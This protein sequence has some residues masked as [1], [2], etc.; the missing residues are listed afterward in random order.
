MPTSAPPPGD[1]A[2]ALALRTT[3]DGV[4]APVRVTPRSSRTRVRGTRNGRLVV[5]LNA[6]PVDGA[7]NQA[8]VR[9][10]ATHLNVPR[11]AVRIVG[12]EHTRQKSV[13][14]T[15]LTAT[16]ILDQLERQT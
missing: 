14:V 5:Q 15:G 4:V 8:L 16:Q 11:R 12:G 7:A 1:S 13:T 2:E 3:D 9:L 10:L 6:P